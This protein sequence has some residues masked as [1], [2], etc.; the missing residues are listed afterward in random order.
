MESSLVPCYVI[1]CQNLTLAVMGYFLTNEWKLKLPRLLW[2]PFDPHISVWLSLI[3]YIWECWGLQGPTRPAALMG[4]FLD[5]L[6]N[7]IILYF[8]LAVFFPVLWNFQVD[9]KSNWLE[10]HIQYK[11]D[12]LFVMARS[13]KPFG[14]SGYFF[15]A[16]Y[17]NYR[18]V[19]KV[20][21]DIL[22]YIF[23][24]RLYRFRLPVTL[25]WRCCWQLTER[26]IKRRNETHNLIK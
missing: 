3:V 6:S 26:N 20:G 13:V 7:L 21:L 24:N 19:I 5:S 22:L 9:F 10:G 23:E 11:K 17:E 4:V 25:T 12:L 1:Y 2:Y 8:C 16:S 14:L 15:V 18:K